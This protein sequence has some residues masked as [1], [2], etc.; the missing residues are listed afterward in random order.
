MLQKHA[1][2]HFDRAPSKSLQHHLTQLEFIHIKG[3]P[4]YKAQCHF[5]K[6][7][8]KGTLKKKKKF[9][10]LPPNKENKFF[11][12]ESHEVPI[13]SIQQSYNDRGQF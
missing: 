11:K 6:K 8:M 5:L 3:D 9:C 7:K 10:S 13:C 12:E 4:D 1:T 2:K